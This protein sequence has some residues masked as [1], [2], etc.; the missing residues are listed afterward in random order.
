MKFTLNAKLSFEFYSYRRVV[1]ALQS[2][3]RRDENDKLTMSEADTDDDFKPLRKKRRQSAI[4]RSISDDDELLSISRPTTRSSSKKSARVSND[5]SDPYLMRPREKTV[6]RSLD[7]S[8]DLYT[9]DAGEEEQEETYDDSSLPT[10]FSNASSV[11]VPSASA[12]LRL[13]FCPFCQGT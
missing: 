3:S 13:G 12:P 2:Y 5:G 8:D 1:G 6:K 10:T 11:E 7:M 4:V 9:P